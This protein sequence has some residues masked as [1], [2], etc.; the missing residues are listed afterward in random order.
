MALIQIKF[1]S[2]TL[3]RQTEILVAIPQK[4][5]QGQIGVK[6]NAEAEKYKTLLLLHGLSDDN[7]IWERRTSIERYATERGIAVVMPS[8]ERGFYTDCK[9]GDKYF[10]FISKEVLQVAREYLP[11]SCKREDTFVAGNS[12]GGYGALKIALKSPESY[13]AAIGLS[14]VADIEKF[15]NE[16]TPDLKKLIFGEGRVPADEDLFALAKSC[17]SNPLRPRIYLYEGRQDFMCEENCRLKGLLEDL[18]YDFT[19]AEDDGAHN[20]ESW[21]K[22]IQT[23][24]AWLLN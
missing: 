6:N 20:W 17:E 12:M 3:G 8:G 15:M 23:A 22:N 10:T 19:Y 4:S 7:S 5:T 1:M 24:L 14:S 2:E 18:D 11:L 21:D 9:Y 13:S 16:Y